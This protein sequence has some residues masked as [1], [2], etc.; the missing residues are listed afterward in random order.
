MSSTGASSKEGRLT[1]RGLTKGY[2]RKGR[3]PI[4][5]LDDC[6]LDIEPGKLTVVMGSS[7]CGKSTLAY[8]LA[9]YV[10]PDAGAVTIDGQ[11]ISGPGP[12]RVLVFQE[13]ALWPWMSVLE[14]VMFGP[15]ARGELGRAESKKK[16]LSLLER[17]GLLEFQDK[18]PGQLSGGMKR[19]AEIAQALMNSPRVMILDEPFRGLDEMT[20]EL[21]QE[22]YLKLFD[23]TA[24]TTLF[25]TSELEEAI[26]LADTILIMDETS[27]RITAK[28]DVDI[29]RPRSF[30]VFDSDAYLAIK[31]QAM[32]QLYSSSKEKHAQA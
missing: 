18:Y 8:I 3:S 10:K 23:E 28:I 20:R 9:G 19:R 22:Y 25:I 24:L 6:N 16:A 11:P 12:D 14:N 17:F 1:A 32:E 26:F 4:T 27:G 31:R 5:V 15:L 13:T 30:E 29:P 7:G 2:Q 21:M